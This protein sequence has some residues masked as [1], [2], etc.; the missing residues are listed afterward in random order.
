[1]VCSGFLV[2]RV[3]KESVGLG[4]LGGGGCVGGTSGEAA[5][6]FYRY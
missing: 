2:G 1:M 3:V 6:G 4:R 5:M